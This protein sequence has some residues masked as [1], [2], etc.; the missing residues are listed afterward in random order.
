MKFEKPVQP[1]RDIKTLIR[2]KDGTIKRI[3]D[4]LASKLLASGE[5]YSANGTITQRA[6]A[7]LEKL[8]KELP[9]KITAVVAN[10][11]TKDLISQS[12]NQFRKFYSS[13]AL[14]IVDGSGY[15]T[16]SEW[17]YKFAKTDKNTTCLFNTFNLHHGPSLH[18]GILLARTNIIY[19]FDSD[20]LI[21]KGGLIEAMYDKISSVETWYGI[22]IVDPVNRKGFD[23][24]NGKIKYIN[25]RCAL[26]NK[27]QYLKYKPFTKH[28][29]P[30]IDAMVDLHDREKDHLLINFDYWPYIT[31]E[32][33]GTV[34]RTGG[35]HL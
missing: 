26:I 3:A 35:Y 6:P 19:T 20:T 18:A 13:L 23:N 24:I 4:P 17:I 28:G 34:K 33:K 32:F 8:T 7:D 12:V 21:V 16:S 30:C 29:A 22:A 1:V 11:K 25:P 15:D 27:E 31:H 5:Y 14:I 2:R 9:N 10:Y